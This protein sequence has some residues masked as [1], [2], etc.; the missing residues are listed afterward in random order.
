MEFTFNLLVSQFA[1]LTPG[2]WRLTCPKRPYWRLY[3]VDRPGCCIRRQG[4][5]YGLVPESLT[6]IAPDTYYQG[7]VSTPLKQFFMHFTCDG[8]FD[9][10]AI[11]IHQV[12]D[13]PWI[14]AF[15]Q[16]VG[17]LGVGIRLRRSYVPFLLQVVANT[18]ASIPDHY[19]LN[20]PREPRL[21]K[22]V[23][24]MKSVHSPPLSNDD[25]SG[26]AGMSKR[27]FLRSFR[28]VMG[29]TPQ[30]W[31]LRKRLEKAMMELEFSSRSIDEIASMTGFCDRNYLSAVFRKHFSTSPAQY[32]RGC[33]RSSDNS[34]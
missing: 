30:A 9:T 11:D 24:A 26:I 28:E 29:A 31:Y 19:V 25:L 5:T 20:R 22:V 34:I 13:E 17:E 3:W 21:E 15:G 8:L 6:L 18:M 10:S 14:E 32:R 7:D 16:R 33:L 27:A 4:C 1:Q 2:N 12:V 23:A